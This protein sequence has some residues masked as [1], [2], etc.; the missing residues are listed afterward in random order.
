MFS[1]K[2][3]GRSSKIIQNTHVLAHGKIR[4]T[5]RENGAL[6][7]LRTW[8]VWLRIKDAVAYTSRWF[9]QSLHISSGQYIKVGHDRFFAVP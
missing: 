4:E 2:E 1:R 5:G 9:L 6:S 7:R 3:V 8:K